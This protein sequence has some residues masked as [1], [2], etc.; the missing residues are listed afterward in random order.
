MY[1]DETKPIELTTEQHVRQLLAQLIIGE[2]LGMVFH[3]ETPFNEYMVTPIDG[4]PTRRL[5]IDAE[6]LHRDAL[7]KRAFELTSQYESAPS[8][9]HIFRL[10]NEIFVTCG[11]YNPTDVNLYII[12]TD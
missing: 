3:P 10:C 12:H 11:L 2:R 8:A 5:Y 6:A 9:E 4:S 7:M 1:I